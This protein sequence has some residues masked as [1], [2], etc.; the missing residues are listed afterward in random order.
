LL[1]NPSSL[2]HFL[3]YTKIYEYLNMQNEKCFDKNQTVPR[4]VLPPSQINWFKFL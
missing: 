3:S 2:C 4:H 1:E